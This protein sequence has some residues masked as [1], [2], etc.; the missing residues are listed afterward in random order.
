MPRR[1]QKVNMEN[2][3]LST[4]LTVVPNL[5]A[6]LYLVLVQQKQLAAMRKELADERERSKVLA[7]N[8]AKEKDDLYNRLISQSKKSNRIQS[9]Q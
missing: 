8:A 6:L 3:I 7:E 4:V 5:S 2:E 1:Y 9:A